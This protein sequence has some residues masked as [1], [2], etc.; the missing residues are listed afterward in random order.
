[1]TWSA[2]GGGAIDANGVYTASSPGTFTITAR[3]LADSTKIATATVTVSTKGKDKDKENVK[4]GKEQPEKIFLSIVESKTRIK[5]LE[6][7]NPVTPV[8]V[9]N[10]PLG[11][12]VNP[13]PVFHLNQ[14]PAVGPSP[15]LISRFAVPAA[16]PAGEAA[17]AAEAAPATEP[18][19]AFI[20]PEERPE[21]GLEIKPRNG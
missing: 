3:S 2:S 9:I 15:I 19:N 6:V 20:Q 11:G 14:P 18:G 10:R 13:L 1:V 4:D 5:D 8:N 17:P 7:L 21:V 12:V 16:A